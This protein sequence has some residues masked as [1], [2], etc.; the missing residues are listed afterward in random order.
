MPQRSANRRERDAGIAAGS[1]CNCVAGLNVTLLISPFENVKGHPILDA[2]GHV[3]VLGLGIDDAFLPTEG[4]ANGEQGRIADHV[5]QLFETR[6]CFLD[7]NRH[8]IGIDMFD[9]SCDLVLHGKL[10]T[11]DLFDVVRCA[12]SVFSVVSAV[13]RFRIALTQSDDPRNHTKQREV[14]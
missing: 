8:R 14:D 5:L 9:L 10:I 11:C 6:G 4:E 12:S 3:E 7:R 1:F 13:S 2:A